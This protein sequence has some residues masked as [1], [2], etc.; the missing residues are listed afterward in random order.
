MPVMRGGRRLAAAPPLADIRRH[1]ATELDRLPE[2]LRRL[3]PDAPYEVHVADRL[4][5]LAAEFDRGV[6]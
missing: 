2:A 6:G 3:A 5:K 4:S 1:A